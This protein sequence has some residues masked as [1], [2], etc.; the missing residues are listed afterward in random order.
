MLRTRPHCLWLTALVL[1]VPTSLGC[2]SSVSHDCAGIGASGPPAPSPEAA[3]DAYLRTLLPQQTDIDYAAW[4]RV[5]NSD[6]SASFQAP[7]ETPGLTIP[8]GQKHGVPY[9]LFVAKGDDG[10]W[11]ATG[12]CV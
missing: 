3:R 9:L 8:G 12:G 6:T 10:D 5:A 11:S 1:S 2:S 4:K 7:I